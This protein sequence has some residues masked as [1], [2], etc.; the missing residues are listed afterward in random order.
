MRQVTPPSV[1]AP[2]R[3]VVQKPAQQSFDFTAVR[4]DP[5][6]SPGPSRLSFRM[7]R[8][9][10]K[11]WVRRMVLVVLPA[12]ILGGLVVRGATDPG[13]HTFVAETRTAIVERLSA[14]PEFAIRGARIAGAS[15]KLRAEI[16]ALVAIPSGASTLNYDVAAAKTA[17][18]KL[19]AVKRARVTL[20]TDGQLD[21]HVTERLPNALWRDGDDTLWLVDI[22]G[23]QVG[24][25]LARADYPRLPLILGRDANKAVAEALELIAAAPG[26]QPRI[27]AFVRVGQRRWNV[28]LDRDMTIMLP[29]AE[30]PAALARVMAWHMGEELLNKG[31]SHIDMR[32]TE[33]P[34]L[35]LTP[36]ALELRPL[37][38]RLRQGT[39][40]ET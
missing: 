2:P 15:P 23:V 28:A 5:V 13:V 35:R 18:N 20:A 27:R 29:E 7:T 8:L 37:T 26:L 9:W 30:A 32:L 38:D 25:A 10:K 1:D 14:R 34:T 12:A 39:G 3:A 21:I 17:V 22:E 6:R 40:E 31:L 4:A 33:R 19:P 36:R 24:P 16:E 11:Q